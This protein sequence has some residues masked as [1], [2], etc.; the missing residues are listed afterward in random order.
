MAS[1]NDSERHALI[2]AMLRVK[3][4]S[5]TELAAT[6]KVTVST[7]SLVSRGRGKSA[8]VETALAQLVG[9]SRQQLWPDRYLE[10]EMN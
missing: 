5:F 4:T 8:K 3:G 9:V 10:T 6:H 1:L 2:K 7:I